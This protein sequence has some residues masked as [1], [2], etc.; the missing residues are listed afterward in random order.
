MEI[1]ENNNSKI[2]FLKDNDIIYIKTMKGNP[3]TLKIECRDGIILIDE[4]FI[5]KIKM[6]KEE[7]KELEKLKKYN[8]NNRK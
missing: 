6:L 7:E 1:I 3:L 8:E 2:L 4:I 5:K